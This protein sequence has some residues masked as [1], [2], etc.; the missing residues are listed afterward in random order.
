[1]SISDKQ[2]LADGHAKAG[3]GLPVPVVPSADPLD[4]L[5]PVK[6]L[7]LPVIVT[8]VAWDESLPDDTYQLLWNGIP[9]GLPKVIAVGEG[10]GS[11]LTLTIPPTWL[12][13]N[14]TY[15]VA[16]RAKNYGGGVG[17]DSDSVTVIVD[18]TPPGGILLA[19]LNF[20]AVVDDGILT[21]AELTALGDVLTAEVPGY[22]G[23]AWGDVIQTFWGAKPGPSHTVTGLEVIQGGMKIDFPR[24]FLEGVGDRAEPVYYVVTD[25]AGNESVKSLEKTFQLLLSES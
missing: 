3:G 11:P 21:S 16:Y 8:L 4:G 14:G 6:S 15:Q 17:N 24:V 13:N 12:L 9:V 18:R 5:L 7:E 19:T 20:P 10:P 22:I 25:R 1:M 2:T 23:I